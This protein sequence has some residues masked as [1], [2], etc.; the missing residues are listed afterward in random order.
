[1]PYN[2]W[3][4]QR[5]VGITCPET[6]VNF[7]ESFHRCFEAP[8][9]LNTTFCLTLTRLPVFP[10]G[11]TPNYS[12]PKESP[13]PS[14][15]LD[16]VCTSLSLTPAPS[17]PITRHHFNPPPTSSFVSEPT[18]LLATK[19]Q[20]DLHV[21]GG[22]SFVLTSMDSGRRRQKRDRY[23]ISSKSAVLPPSPLQAPFVTPHPLHLFP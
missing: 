20:R 7:I 21:R 1:M 15:G 2:R 10:G 18:E 12:F 3:L 8:R 19:W 16:T 5:F 23:E 9:P 4:V 17:N 13:L 6:R 14:G 11:C 22:G